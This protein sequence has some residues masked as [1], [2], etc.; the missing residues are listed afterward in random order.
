MQTSTWTIICSNMIWMLGSKVGWETVALSEGSSFTQIEVAGLKPVSAFGVI[1][2]A[3]F[4][5][6]IVFYAVGDQLL[7]FWEAWPAG[8][9]PWSWACSFWSAPMARTF[10]PGRPSNIPTVGWTG[11]G[12]WP[13]WCSYKDCSTGLES[14]PKLSYIRKVSPH[15]DTLEPETEKRGLECSSRNLPLV[16]NSNIGVW[17]NELPENP[18]IE[19]IIISR[20]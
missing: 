5:T 20:R 15:Q 1:T 3:M 8:S 12:H 7:L 18:K 14:V 2:F 4:S 17:Q 16:K 9:D 19:G 6:K 11:W 10:A 13:H